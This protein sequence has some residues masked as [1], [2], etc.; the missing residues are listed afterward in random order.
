MSGSAFERL[1]KR[2]SKYEDKVDLARED[3]VD[4]QRVMEVAGEALRA[5]LKDGQ[6]S[7]VDIPGWLTKPPM[8]NQTVGDSKTGEPVEVWIVQWATYWWHA[9]LWLTRNHR[10]SGIMLPSARISRIEPDEWWEGDFAFQ[11]LPCVIHPE[12]SDETLAKI[13]EE[14]VRASAD[15]CGFLA[16]CSSNKGELSPSEGLNASTKARPELDSKNQRIR[17]LDGKWHDVNDEPLRMLKVLF[18]A[19]GGWVGGKQIEHET[20]I[21]SA[22]RAKSRMPKPVRKLIESHRRNG[23]RIPSLLPE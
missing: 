21:S 14:I 4:I 13:W 15:A 11:V 1:A 9:V 19:E 18:D 17:A 6:L 5:V 10:E 12:T 8:A 2:F 3:D 20:L 7:L 16:E 23:Y 22:S